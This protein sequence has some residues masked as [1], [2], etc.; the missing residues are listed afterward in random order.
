M[1]IYIQIQLGKNIFTT[2]AIHR[3][4]Q[5]QWNTR[6]LPVYINSVK[7]EKNAL[8]YVFDPYKTSIKYKR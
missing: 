4:M 2:N 1:N 5:N 6:A 7:H 3:H 8:K